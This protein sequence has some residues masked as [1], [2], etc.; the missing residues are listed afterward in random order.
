MN[1][2]LHNRTRREQC[3]ADVPANI[4]RCRR[5]PA[6]QQVN[7]A[8]QPKAKRSLSACW[9]KEIPYASIPA[10]DKPFCEEAAEQKERQSWLDY[11]MRGS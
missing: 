5:G 4:K 3:L 11:E 8:Q 7:A 2:I 1:T 9:K 10:K 6:P